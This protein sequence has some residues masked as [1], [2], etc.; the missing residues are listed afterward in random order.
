MIRTAYIYYGINEQEKL[1]ISCYHEQT[2]AAR[3]Y[4][5]YAK[6]YGA[7]LKPIIEKVEIVIPTEKDITD[8]EIE[9]LLTLLIEDEIKDLILAN[10]ITDAEIKAL[11]TNEITDE[12]IEALLTL[13]TLLTED[14]TKDLILNKKEITEE[15][16]KK[17]ILNKKIQK[18]I[19]DAILG[20]LQEIKNALNIEPKQVILAADVN[21][22]SP[23][24]E[25]LTEFLIRE[26]FI[27]KIFGD[28]TPIIRILESS[29][30]EV[31]SK[32]V[33]RFR[34]IERTSMPPG[35]AIVR[36]K[37]GHF[38]DSTDRIN[39]IFAASEQTFS[40]ESTHLFRVLT[41]S[42]KEIPEKEV[43]ASKDT[44]STYLGKSSPGLGKSNEQMKDNVSLR[45]RTSTETLSLAFFNNNSNKKTC[46][47][48]KENCNQIP[49]KAEEPSHP[50]G[51]LQSNI[52]TI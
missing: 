11:L 48:T 31:A 27:R 36:V 32:A 39:E 17:L 45:K 12:G 46:Q 50:D 41:R 35:A 18:A 44:R 30:K 47:E 16:I 13:L 33:R 26:A 19:Q 21:L 29:L 49:S 7:P 3:N 43:A 1:V 22:C 2:T 38:N 34:E 24:K 4:R 28:T 10:K 37:S 51:I 8:A 23:T 6:H 15:R 25:E 40:P 14:E 5:K 42:K 9:A 20:K 52:T